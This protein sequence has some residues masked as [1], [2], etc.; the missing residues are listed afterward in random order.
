MSRSA[1]IPLI[2]LILISA[3][4]FHALVECSYSS[5]AVSLKNSTYYCT[6]CL[7]G[8]ASSNQ[9]VSACAFFWYVRVPC[10]ALA[11]LGRV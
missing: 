1:L 8:A 10:P 9:R 3:L 6:V 11:L 4:F 7:A 5:H 2:A